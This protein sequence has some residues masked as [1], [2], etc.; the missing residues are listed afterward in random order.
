MQPQKRVR[1]WTI[2][3]YLFLFGLT[4]SKVYSRATPLATSIN[5]NSLGKSI[6]IKM[7]YDS[8][9]RSQSCT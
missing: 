7:Y 5:I 8:S 9:Q 3:W 2:N 1:E 4:V 6:L